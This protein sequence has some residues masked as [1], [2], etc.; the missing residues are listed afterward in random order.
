MDFLVAFTA[1]GLTAGA[2]PA[3]LAGGP[4]SA[5]L[6]VWPLNIF[7]SLLVPFFIVL[8]LTALL[9]GRERRAARNGIRPE[10]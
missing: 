6:D 4:S 5:P 9:H 3:L 10:V 7:P 2:F 1:A 8:H